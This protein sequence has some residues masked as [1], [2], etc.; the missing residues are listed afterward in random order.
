[1]KP[2][3]TTYNEMNALDT[4]KRF[5]RN[6][7]LT[8]T[9]IMSSAENAKER[10]GVDKRATPQESCARPERRDVVLSTSGPR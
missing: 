9:V 10:I 4:N 8:R 2:D 1:M 7:V 6:E 5:M 3:Q